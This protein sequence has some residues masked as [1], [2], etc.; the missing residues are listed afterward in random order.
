MYIFFLVLTFIQTVNKVDS[1]NTLT[2]YLDKYFT[3]YYF[4]ILSGY[5]LVCRTTLNVTRK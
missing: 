2:N 4:G 3:E 5:V 1:N